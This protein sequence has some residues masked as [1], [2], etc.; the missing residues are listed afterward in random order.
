[1]PPELSALRAIVGM[2]ETGKQLGQVSEEVESTV[3]ARLVLAALHG[4]VDTLAVAPETDVIRES[5][6]FLR[7][8]VAADTR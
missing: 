8:A 3:C 6:R 1:M 4:A 2:L 7:S 5:V